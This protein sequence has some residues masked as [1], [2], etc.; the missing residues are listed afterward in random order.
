MPLTRVKMGVEVG[1][2]KK[3]NR[4]EANRRSRNIKGI[5]KSENTRRRVKFNGAHANS[6]NGVVSKTRDIWQ[7]AP[8]SMMNGREDWEGKG[9][10]WEED[11]ERAV[12]RRR[13]CREGVVEEETEEPVVGIGVA[14]WAVRGGCLLRAAAR[15]ARA[16]SMLAHTGRGVERA[17]KAEE[18]EEK[19]IKNKG[20]RTVRPRGDAG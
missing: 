13:R 10:L 5:E 1:L 8:V 19:G 12:E 18:E 9:W 4:N 6:G 3:K 14:T 16:S 17:V 20:W 15:A 7:E 11:A 2:S